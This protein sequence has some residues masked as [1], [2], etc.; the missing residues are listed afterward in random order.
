[1]DLAW[2]LIILPLALGLLGFVEPCTIGS[3]LLFVQYVEDEPPRIRIVQAVIFTVTRAL[4]IGG[5]GAT[6]AIIGTA[7]A[8]F[9]Q[10]GW[11]VLGS[12]YVVL[13]LLYLSGNAGRV[14]R[15]IGPRL[16][17]LSGARGAVVLA[18]LFGLNIPTCAAPLL[19]ALLAPA[20]LD[21]T[22]VAEGFVMLAVF[23]LALSLPLV[24]AVLWNS[25]RRFLDRLTVLSRRVPVVLGLLFVALG[26][27]SIYFALFVPPGVQ[28]AAS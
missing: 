27:W 5:L 16:K 12:L 19:A 3:S 1:M 13:G 11:L 25:A 18:I 14:S 24:V 17:R 10:A 7:F 23:G 20:A 9:Q 15:T 26:L 4:F 21:T 28:T 22:Q 2:S 6:A 8:G